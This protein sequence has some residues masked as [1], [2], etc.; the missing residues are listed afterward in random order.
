MRYYDEDDAKALNA[1]PWQ[2]ELLKANPS[3]LGWGPG[4]D[5]MYAIGDGGWSSSLLIPDWVTFIN[6]WPLND[7]NECVNFYFSVQ[8]ESEECD[9]CHG[10]YYHPDSQH[11]VRTFYQHSC[12]PGERPW[13]ANI[14]EDEA[15]ALVEAGRAHE[16]TT[17]SEFNAAQGVI[18]CHDAINRHI[19]IAQRC[20]RLGLPVYCDKCDGRGYV[21][22]ADHAHVTLT[23]WWLHPRKGCSRGLRIERIERDDL[24]AVIDFLQQA[25]TRND[26]RFR[27]VDRISTSG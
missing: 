22:T 11:I 26:D 13:N 1:E 19:L 9:K 23:L 3:Y 15:A 21:Y 6:E 4:E 10:E 8:R 14:T 2:I 20:K 12:R 25:R 17:A 16:M 5:A 7:L 18:N 24:P 27:G